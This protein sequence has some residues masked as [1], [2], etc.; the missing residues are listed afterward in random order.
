[1]G[2]ICEYDGLLVSWI[3]H[4]LGQRWKDSACVINVLIQKLEVNQK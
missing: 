1:M 4:V 2:G 3:G